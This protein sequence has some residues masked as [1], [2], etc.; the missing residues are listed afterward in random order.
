MAVSKQYSSTQLHYLKA[1]GIPAWML[2]NQTEI[3]IEKAVS[4]STPSDS[5]ASPGLKHLPNSQQDEMVASSPESTEEQSFESW[6]AERVLTNVGDNSRYAVTTGP[7]QSDLLVLIDHLQNGLSP[8]ANRLLDAMLKSIE[9]SRM[10][11]RVASVAKDKVATSGENT[12]VQMLL[13]KT[14][15]KVLIFFTCVDCDHE[16]SDPAVFTVDRPATPLP[17]VDC[18]VAHH[19]EYVLGH[20]HLKRTVWEVLKEVRAKLASQL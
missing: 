11:C 9:Q 7:S 15:P 10:T 17:G 4:I 18:F 3:N 5:V 8:A 20:Q 19:P 1:M 2:R 13:A 16:F 6:L 12:S 14:P